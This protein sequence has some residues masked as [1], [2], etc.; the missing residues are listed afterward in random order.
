MQQIDIGGVLSRVFKTYQENFVVL[1]AG[2]AG[3]CSC[4]IAIINALIRTSVTSFIVSILVTIL[5]LVGTYLYAGMVV[6]LVRD[7]QDGRRDSS[8]GELFSSVVPVLGAPDP[9]R[10]C[11]PVS[12]SASASCC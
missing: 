8:L 3:R 10:A 2:G 7:I 1:A 9:G 4:P 6:Q 5:Q 12:G 11:S